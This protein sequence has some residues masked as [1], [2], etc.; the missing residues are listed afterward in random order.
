MNRLLLYFVLAY[1]ISWAIW[2]PLILLKYG[3]DTL[4]VL[5]EYHHYLGSFGPMLAAF[6]VRFIY[7]GRAGVKDLLKRL[8]QWK[9]NGIWYV[10]VLA[11]PVALTIVAGYTSQL[12]NGEPFSMKGFSTNNEFPQFGPLAY[13]MFNFLTFGV[14]EETG[15]R[16]FA[17]PALQKRFSALVSTLILTVFWA[18]W[19]I[20]AFTYRPLYSQMDAAGIA[21][22]LMSMLMGSVILTWLYNSAKGSLLI[23]S[24]FHAMIELIFISDN[25]TPRITQYEGMA[26]AV[27]VLLIVFITKPLNLS[28]LKRQKSV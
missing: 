14:G 1:L 17:L 21:G 20:S 9:V 24:L 12:I 4:P 2:L 18:C 22:F 28:F 26:F 3:I 5:P 16:G 6:I 8:V 10:I 25:I 23:V 19:H 13:F 15:W 11:V 7:E 27:A